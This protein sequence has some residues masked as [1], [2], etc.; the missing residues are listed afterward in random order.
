MIRQMSSC[1]TALCRFFSKKLSFVD[2]MQIIILG[3]PHNVPGVDT[4]LV[5]GD[6]G[7]Q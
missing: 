7:K 4:W 6:T 1:N 5:L 3:T 2:P